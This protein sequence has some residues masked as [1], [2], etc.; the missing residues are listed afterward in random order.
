MALNI[1]ERIAR[2]LFDYLEYPDSK[3]IYRDGWEKWLKQKPKRKSR[4]KKDRR[5]D[6]DAETK[7]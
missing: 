2:S 5:E 3:A 6:R 1:P 4:K 7:T